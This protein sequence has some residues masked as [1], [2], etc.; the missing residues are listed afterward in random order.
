MS[1]N[2]PSL[3]KRLVRSSGWF[4]FVTVSFWVA[5]GIVMPVLLSTLL[6]ETRIALYGQ[7]GDMFGSVNSFFSGLAMLAALYTVRLQVVERSEASERQMEQDK[8]QAE[9]MRLANENVLLQ[10]QMRDEVELSKLRDA[11]LKVY[12]DALMLENDTYA[13]LSARRHLK[14]A[15][16]LASVNFAN[17]DPLGDCNA[18][19]HRQT[20]STITLKSD[21]IMLKLI[22]NDLTP[23]LCRCISAF[24]Q[25][26][27]TY[28][29]PDASEDIDAASRLIGERKQKLGESIAAVW[30]QAQDLHQAKYESAVKEGAT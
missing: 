20:T 4:G 8:I 14:N 26:V 18:A 3:L 1:E 5:F 9:E 17:G 6:P 10:K 2:K 7:V 11:L 12:S 23:D 30:N 24:D 29:E 27:G 21:V 15:P 25:T 28:N 22:N 19:T 16:R 13:L